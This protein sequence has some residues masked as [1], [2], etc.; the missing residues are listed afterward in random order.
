M[1]GKRES[2]AG[3][4]VDSVHD[5]WPDTLVARV[6]TPN[7]G[8]LSET[9]SLTRVI[10][11]SNDTTVAAK[12][13]DGTHGGLDKIALSTTHID[14]LKVSLPYSIKKVISAQS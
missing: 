10:V 11:C 4:G 8:T 1:Y 7:P 6:E 14:V 3:Y 5:Q 2:L 9:S 13:L 12:Y